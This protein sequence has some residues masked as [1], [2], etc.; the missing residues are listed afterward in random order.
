MVL[1]FGILFFFFGFLGECF[2]GVRSIEKGVIYYKENVFIVWCEE[3]RCG[4][5]VLYDVVYVRIY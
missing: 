3:L 5:M 1:F 2:W 4:F